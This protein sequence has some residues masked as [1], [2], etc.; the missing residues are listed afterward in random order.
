M[1]HLGLMLE[2]FFPSPF[3]EIIEDWPI[4]KLS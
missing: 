1:I 3:K 4:Y 2:S